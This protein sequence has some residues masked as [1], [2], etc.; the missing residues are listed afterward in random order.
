MGRCALPVRLLPHVG[1][2]GKL[3]QASSQG[4]DAQKKTQ[5]RQKLQLNLAVFCL[6]VRTLALLASLVFVILRLKDLAFRS[7]PGDS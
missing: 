6:A 2:S 4:H 1:P 7:C 5:M 3:P